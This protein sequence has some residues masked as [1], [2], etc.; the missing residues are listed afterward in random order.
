MAWR[1]MFSSQFQVSPNDKRKKPLDLSVSPWRVTVFWLVE[2]DWISQALNSK[3][4]AITRARYCRRRHQ[5]L[6]NN[7][8]DE[9]H[10]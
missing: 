6:A 10:L 1:W 8:K 3:V 7:A 5:S 2:M 9:M 4:I